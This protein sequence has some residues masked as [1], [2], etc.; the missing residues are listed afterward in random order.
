MEA[1]ALEQLIPLTPVI[2]QLPVP[3]GVAPPVGPVTEAVNVKV[4][5]RET[6]EALVVT[7]TEG[8][9]ELNLINATELGP[10]AL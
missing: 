10:A 2:D 9:L 1:A 4:E 3:V 5:P 6:A 7:V 8:T